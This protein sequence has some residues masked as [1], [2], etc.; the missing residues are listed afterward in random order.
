MNIKNKRG[1]YRNNHLICG[2]S[3]RLTHLFAVLTY[4]YTPFY[5]SFAKTKALRKKCFLFL[6]RCVP[7]AEH[8]AHCVRDDGFALWCALRVWVRNT[9]HHFAPSAQYITVR[10]HIT[11]CLQ[12]KTSLFTN[13]KICGII[14][15]K[16]RY[17]Y[18]WI[19]APWIING[20]IRWC[21]TIN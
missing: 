8:N 21:F 6:E 4:I 10:K 18:I 7:Q 19:Q 14:L 5:C 13:C 12:G 20:I 1:M 16:A 9:S 11:T 15:S 3:H 2:L 17:Y